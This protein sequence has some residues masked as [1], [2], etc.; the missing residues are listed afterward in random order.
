MMTDGHRYIRTYI[1]PPLDKRYSPIK[2]SICGP[3]NVHL[4]RHYREENYII[5]Y[6]FINNYSV[7]K[8]HEKY[9][10]RKTQQNTQIRDL[11]IPKENK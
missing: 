1:Y 4:I 6:L 7:R 9:L 3:N 8:I 2:S 10:S 11:K 5:F